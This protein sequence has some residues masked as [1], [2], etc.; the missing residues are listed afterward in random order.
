MMQQEKKLERAA[1]GDV[2]F[3]VHTRSL[4]RQVLDEALRLH[5]TE[6]LTPNYEN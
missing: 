5:H 3:L 1:C 6:P 4:A 2:L